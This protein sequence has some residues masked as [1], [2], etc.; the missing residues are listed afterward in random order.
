MHPR[1]EQAG[2]GLVEALVSVLLTSVVILALIMTRLRLD[3]HDHRGLGQKLLDGTIASACGLGF[4]LLLFRAVELPF[5]AELT[6]FFSDYSKTVAHGANVVNVIIDDFRGVDT[7]G[8]IS[9][10]TI[11]GLAILALIRLRAAPSGRTV[12]DPDA[13]E[14]DRA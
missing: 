3:I 5:N 7:L 11:T 1:G 12:N 8:E 14:G 6:R 10:V 4:M 13:G 2:Y 9:V